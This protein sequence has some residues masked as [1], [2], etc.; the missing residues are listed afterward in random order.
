MSFS[1]YRMAAAWIET[2][3][4]EAQRQAELDALRRQAGP[5]HRGWL[6]RQHRRLLCKTGAVLISFG[7]R[8]QA[9]D[10]SQTLPLNNGLSKTR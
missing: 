6:S 8:L 10:L 2:R 7:R 9:Y 5:L 3:Q 4:A 1:D